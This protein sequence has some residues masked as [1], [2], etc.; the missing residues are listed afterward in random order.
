[1]LPEVKPVP[2]PQAV[3]R[4]AALPPKPLPRPCIECATP[5][6]TANGRTIPAPVVA[7][8]ADPVDQE[9]DVASIAP[10][11]PIPPQPV[12]PQAGEGAGPGLLVRGGQA[13][14]AG[15]GQIVGTAWDLSGQAVNGLVRGVRALTF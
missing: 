5:A 11:G 2:A 14:V 13:V 12:G 6:A 10:D 7:S 1:M 4:V 9:F 15:S 3:E 8:V